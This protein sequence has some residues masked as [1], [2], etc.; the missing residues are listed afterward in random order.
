MPIK[1]KCNCGQTLTVP[2]KLAGK[3]GKCPKCGQTLKIP[4]PKSKAATAASSKP[5][6]KPTASAK[7]PASAAVGGAL[8]SLLDDA[9]LVQKSGPTC[10]ECMVDIKPG[11]VI[12]TSCGYNLESGEKMTGYDAKDERPEFDNLY[13]QEASEN[14]VRD[15]LMDSRRDKASMPWWVI[16]SFLI[17]TMTLIAAGIVIV[18]GQF[19]TPSAPDTLIGKV[20]RWPVFITLGL[21]SLITGTA[22]SVFAHLSITV[23]GF[24]R[25]IQ[26]GLLCFFLPV[27]YSVI[28]GIMN[29]VD[30]KAPVKAIMMAIV[31]IGLGI[32]LIVQ[33][34]GF[35]LVFDAFR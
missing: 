12:C 29:W 24:G 6:S 35:N 17:G 25:S 2:S 4:S 20:Q 13:L 8:D 9:G 1:F 31:F 28:Y 14:M 23:F 16:M 21:T 18:D 26:Q 15:K 19:G 11:T 7:A 5:K 10:P 32:F 34:G 30:N 22:I 33:G 3:T 27:L